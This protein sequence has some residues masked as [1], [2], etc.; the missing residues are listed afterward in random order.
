[1]AVIKHQNAAPLIRDAIVLD[2]GDV[3]RQAQ[4]IREAAEA[5]AR[6]IVESAQ[7]SAES[8]SQ[9]VHTD[10]AEKG[11]QQGFDQGLSQGREQGL[12]E[13]HKQA[14]ETASGQL[15]AITQAWTQALGQWDAQ[16]QDMEREARAAVLDF[17]IQLAKKV[18]HRLIEVDP[19][20]AVDQVQAVLSHVMRPMDVCIQICGDDRP[21]LE[22]AMPKL[23]AEFS[24]V[25]HVALVDD[26]DVGRGGCVLGYG[27]GRIDATIQTQIQRLVE[28]IVS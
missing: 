17:A 11:H 13:G 25:K 15:E 9:R 5:K 21:V 27:Q 23:L 18:V 6:D 16:R 22:E 24:Q 10:S 1:M 3:V 19:A 28:L 2:L 7:R 4:R 26:P 20:V 14:M 12:Q 8:M